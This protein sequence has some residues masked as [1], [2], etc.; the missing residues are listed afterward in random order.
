[1]NTQ[2]L[3][4][5]LRTVPETDLEL[6]RISWQAIGEDGR[7][8]MQKAAFLSKEIDLA[9]G[10]AQA[11]IQASQRIRWSLRNLLLQNP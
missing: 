2:Q 7:L 1:M 9:V 11:Y 4:A 5:A 6:I 3:I 8:D 10:Q